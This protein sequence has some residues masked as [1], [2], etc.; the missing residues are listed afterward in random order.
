MLAFDKETSLVCSFIKHDSRAI[1]TANSV[2]CNFDCFNI[3]AEVAGWNSLD[4]GL[5]NYFT[6]GY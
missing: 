3:N 6:Y 2:R 1:N 5:I 4:V